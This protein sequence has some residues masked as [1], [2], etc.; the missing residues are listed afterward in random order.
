MEFSTAAV[1][2]IGVIVILM[3]VARRLLRFAFRLLLAGLLLV[4]ILITI[5]LG[6]WEGWFGRQSS[7]EPRSSQTRSTR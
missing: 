6:W 4:V 7:R 2:A 5:T 3:I 1:I